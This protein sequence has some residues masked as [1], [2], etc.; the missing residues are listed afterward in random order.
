[1]EKWEEERQKFFVYLVETYHLGYEYKLLNDVSEFI[2]TQREEAFRQGVEAILG[3]LINRDITPQQKLSEL[4]TVQ[5]MQVETLKAS[6][7]SPAAARLAQSMAMQEDL[8]NN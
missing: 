6:L 4:Q 7:L 5:Q 8:A 1:M 2:R 3:E